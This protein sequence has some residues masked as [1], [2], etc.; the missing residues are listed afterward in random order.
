[1]KYRCAPKPDPQITVTHWERT[2]EDNIFL[3]IQNPPL[4]VQEEE[5]SAKDAT[6]VDLEECKKIFLIIIFNF[7]QIHIL[8]FH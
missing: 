8:I 2:S 1:M 3:G 6:Q 4:E 5:I 7:F